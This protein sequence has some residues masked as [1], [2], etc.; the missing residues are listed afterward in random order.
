LAYTISTTAGGSTAFDFAEGKSATSF[1]ISPS[2]QPAADR[3]GN[4]YFT[5]NNRVIRV[6]PDGTATTYA[7]TGVAGS[8][9]PDGVLATSAPLNNPGG[10]LLDPQGRLLIFEQFG[11]TGYRLLRVELNGTITTIAGNGQPPVTATDGD[12]GPAT[13]ARVH[14]ILGA[15]DNT[16][17]LFILDSA[18]VPGSFTEN[19]N[20]RRIGADG[21]ITTVAK[22]VGVYPSGMASDG[23]NIYLA[24]L[25]PAVNRVARLTSTG[26]FVPITGTKVGNSG[27]GGPSVQAL[28]NYPSGIAFD[29]AGNLHV[30]DGGNNRVRTIRNDP[31]T[32]TVASGQGVISTTAGTG[33]SAF[34]DDGA[35]V[36]KSPISNPSVITVDPSDNIYVSDNGAGRFRRY[37]LNGTFQTIAGLSVTDPL[38]DGGPAT[39]AAF[40]GASAIFRDAAGNLLVTDGA[41]LRKVTP[42]GRISTIAGVGVQGNSG[43]NGPAVQALLNGPG[44]V[45]ED[46]AG[47]VYML[48][49]TALWKITLDGTLTRM[50]TA[51]ANQDEGPA[52]K[53]DLSGYS[54]AI[55]AQDNIYIGAQI[56]VR[57][58]TPA[59]VVTRVAGTNAFVQ[60]PLASGDARG[61]YIAGARGLALDANGNLFIGDSFNHRILKVTPA[62]QFTT[63]AGAFGNPGFSGDGGP[64][65]KAL[66]NRPIGMAFDAWGNFYFADQANSRVR[67]ITPDGLISTVAGSA[68]SVSIPDGGAATAGQVS[69]SFANS[70]ATDPAGNVLLIADNRVR[71]LTGTKLAAGGVLHAALVTAGPVAPGLRIFIRGTEL[72]PPGAG[73]SAIRVLFD[74]QPADFASIDG[75]QIVTVVPAGVAGAP[76]TQLEVEIRGARTNG[77]SLPVVAALP[78]ILSIENSDGS[79]NGTASPAASGSTVVLLVTGDGNADPSALSVQIGGAAATVLNASPSDSTPGVRRVTVQLPDGTADGSSVVIAVGDAASPDSVQIRVQ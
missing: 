8:G 28:F 70:V 37:R 56:A 77:L 78:G 7:G 1:L 63:V 57:K 46:S 54:L 20:V 69:L 59:G 29:S 32:T 21:H 39:Q 45:V 74:G 36:L 6:A 65:A 64:A 16:G 2:F 40:V 41:R 66:V 18:S 23:P 49:G 5:Q 51:G 9:A 76:V 43:E 24:D 72:I 68:N 26:T 38:G 12:G 62:G 35:S 11:S 60:V 48:D 79:I 25:N 19:L 58:L 3:Q 73:S 47:N 13:S 52:A 10:V 4:F 17:A 67:K 22:G 50:G 31:P 14:A 42:D 33:V 30:V 15:Y 61:A 53:V 44:S 71:K 27:D 34:S 75:A 55:D